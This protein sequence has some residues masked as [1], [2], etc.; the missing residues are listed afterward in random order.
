MR[1][2]T[3]IAALS[4]TLVAAG[5]LGAVPGMDQNSDGGTV[6]QNVPDGAAKP[7]TARQL[8]DDNVAPMLAACASCHAG[9]GTV[10]GPKFLGTTLLSA[11]FY[12]ALIS[13]TRYVNNDPTQSLLNTH[14]HTT[15]IGTDL[16]V[17]QSKFVSDWLLQ[18]GVERVLAPPPAPA[19]GAAVAAELVKF[20]KCMTQADWDAA[21]MNDLQNQTT[22]GDA[23]ECYSCHQT[24]L[25]NVYLSK[26]ST[27]NFTRIQT[28]PNLLKLAAADVKADG[29]LNDI[30]QADRFQNRG[31]LP[32]HPGYTL[33]TARLNAINTFF[34]STYTKYK[35]GN[36][37]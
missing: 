9:P 31:Q 34:M 32:G 14:K 16:T 15:G 12:V 29:S 5:C 1:W 13:D 18:E 8:F 10:D 25:Y 19:A 4:L 20:G 35:A 30:I 33:T 3:R 6:N 37:P 26:I 22:L 7:P 17:A 21:G 27:D 23:G 28:S 11:D 36:C 24:G 2:E